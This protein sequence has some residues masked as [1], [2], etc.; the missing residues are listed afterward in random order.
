MFQTISNNPLKKKG[1]AFNDQTFI[2]MSHQSEL[3]KKEW[4]QQWQSV[5][6]GDFNKKKVKLNN[7]DE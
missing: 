3:G 6:N 1:K 4:Q 2:N 5:G 7:L